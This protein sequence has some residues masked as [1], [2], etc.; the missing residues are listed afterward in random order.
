[1]G[2][3][4]EDEIQTNTT[5]SMEFLEELERQLSNPVPAFFISPEVK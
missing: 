3:R 2:P 5:Y 1:M 4:R